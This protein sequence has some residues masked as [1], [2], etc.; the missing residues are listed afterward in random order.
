[1]NSYWFLNR[2]V[3]LHY[4]VGNDIGSRV[5]HGKIEELVSGVSCKK[6]VAHWMSIMT[7]AL[8]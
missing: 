2:R 8:V 6:V 5:E 3:K 4:N 1:M 7:S